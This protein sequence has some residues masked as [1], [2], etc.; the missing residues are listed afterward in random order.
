MFGKFIKE[1]RLSKKLGLREFCMA[2]GYDPSNWSKVEREIAPPA[3]DSEI[4][5]KWAADLGLEEGSGDWKKFF[6]YAA[7]DAGMIPKYILEDEELVKKLPVFFRT[8]E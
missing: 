4:L 8:L 5:S 1:I 6:E 2:N 3:K 7:L